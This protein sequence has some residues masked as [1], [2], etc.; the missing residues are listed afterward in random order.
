MLCTKCNQNLAVYHNSKTVNGEYINEHLCNDCMIDNFSEEISTN[1][2]NPII[3]SNC[4]KTCGCTFDEFSSTGK[5]GCSDCYTNFSEELKPVI[6]KL[7]GSVMHYGKENSKGLT[8][9]EK[10]YFELNRQLKQAVFMEDYELAST[11]KEK[12]LKFRDI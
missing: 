8:E 3:T 12:I 11:L 6:N 10:E 9:R 4:C 5:L 7:H 1:Y 2:F